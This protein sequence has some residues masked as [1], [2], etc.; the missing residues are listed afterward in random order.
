MSI[1]G[2][3]RTSNFHRQVREITPKSNKNKNKKEI[4]LLREDPFQMKRKEGDLDVDKKLLTMMIGVCCKLETGV[5]PC[6]SFALLLPPLSIS[7]GI[8]LRIIDRLSQ[9]LMVIS[10]LSAISSSFRWRTFSWSVCVALRVRSPAPQ[11]I[12]QCTWWRLVS[13]FYI[14]NRNRK[15]KREKERMS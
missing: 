6:S 3:E 5:P 15:R 11:P 7:C 9:I 13:A 1:K 12:E 8:R 4:P 2:I 10:K 14:R